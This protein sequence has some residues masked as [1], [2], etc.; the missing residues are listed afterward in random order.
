[1][2]GRDVVAEVLAKKRVTAED[3]R[4]L[5]QTVYNDGAAETGEVERLFAID[6]SV[7]D[8]DPTWCELFVEAVT[9]YIVEQ[10]EPHGYVN[11]ENAD[12]LISRISRDGLVKTVTEIELLV[13]VLDRS[14]SSPPRLV[15]FALNQV[16]KAVVDG[17]GL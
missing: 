6:E 2:I 16:K 15:V 5:R 12:W 10:V 11:E 3:V 4:A 8:A 14:Q 7:S 13:K 17:E 9:D 1:M